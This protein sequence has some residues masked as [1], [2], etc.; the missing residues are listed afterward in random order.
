VVEV[1]DSDRLANVGVCLLNVDAGALRMFEL[2][3][4]DAVHPVA[5]WPLSCIRRFGYEPLRFTVETGR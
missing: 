4:D 5:S 3:A 1:I 2:N